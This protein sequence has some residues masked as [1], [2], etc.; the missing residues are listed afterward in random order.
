MLLLLV[1]QFALFFLL[2]GWG[3]LF[4][5]LLPNLWNGLSTKLVTGII[6][7]SLCS[8][9]IGFF[10][11]LN[12]YYEIGIILI[13]IIGLVKN[14]R[15]ISSDLKYLK[16]KT[17]L[18]FAFIVIVIS[19]FAPFINDHFGYYVSTIKWLNEFGLVKGIS[20][21]S[22]VLGQQSTWH[23]FQASID[24][25]VDPFMRVNA[26]LLLIFILYSI[27]NKR[28]EL[29]ILTP[30]FLLFV[31]SPSPDLI[32]YIISLI[33][34][35]ELLKANPNYASLWLVSL[36]LMTIKPIIFWLPLLIFILSLKTNI[37]TLFKFKNIVFSLFIVLPFFA[38]Q[39]W[40]FG[41]IL[42]PLQTNLF[43]LDWKPNTLLL[44]LSNKNALLKTYDFQYTIKEITSWNALD[45]IFK[46]FT[47]SG[48]KPII[49]IL[50]VISILVFGLYSFLKKKKTY[51][52]LWLCIV[53]KTIVIFQFSGQYRFMLDGVLV[54]S[55]LLIISLQIPS[56]YYLWISYFGCFIVFSIFLFPSIIKQNISSFYVGQ[57]M[58]NPELKQVYEPLNYSIA[59]YSKNK[60]TNFEFYTPNNYHLMLDVPIPCLIPIALDEFRYVNDFPVAY[61]KDN[62]QKGFYHKTLT[63][64]QKEK[65][66]N[67]L[68]NYTVY[69]PLD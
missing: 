33:I 38:K 41:D 45:K 62:L 21:I 16:D 54:L 61:D 24:T 8:S 56:K 23:V 5:K 48:F 6:S 57:L 17:F 3:N 4:E 18:F 46:W 49:H 36:F 43:D 27:E 55:I 12:V 42:F 34:T 63:L 44:E 40:C 37:K 67:L 51:I 31:H 69:Y 14:H 28:K 64:K 65:L 10:L 26:T 9:I 35:L 29:L 30:L 11:P 25:L 2:I 59:D 22:L 66:I 50:I 15:T 32:I 19:T 52:L 39:L 7:I 47:L 68:K 58:G 60:I 13:G 1:S 53:I 20:N